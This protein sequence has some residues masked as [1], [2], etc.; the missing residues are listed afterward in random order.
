MTP[1]INNILSAPSPDSALLQALAKTSIQPDF[2]T[3]LTGA[4]QLAPLIGQTLSTAESAR[5]DALKTSK[6]LQAQALATAGNIVG[7]IYGGNPT[8]GSSAL[9]AQNGKAPDEGSAKKDAGS[10]AKPGG[11]S[12]S[13]AGSGDA[14]GGGGT[15]TGTGST[16]TG[17][18]GTGG[19]E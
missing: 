14:G 7:G 1:L 3:G 11:S 6:D 16:G 12:G 17:T 4:A 9:A 18:G 13:G 8:A 10:G 2:S 5:A 19:G 15:E